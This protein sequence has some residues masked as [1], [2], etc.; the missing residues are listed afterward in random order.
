M[1]CNPLQN[2]RYW[3][4]GLILAFAMP[5]SAQTTVQIGT[6]TSTFG[7]GTSH[8][9]PYGRYYT[10]GKSSFIYT[11]TELTNAGITAGSTINAIG[12]NVPSALNG[13]GTIP[14]FSISML[15]ISG[16]T[17]SNTTFLTGQTQVLASANYAPVV[18]WNTHMLTTPFIYNGGDLVVTTCF[19]DPISNNWSENASV[20][21]STVSNA[22]QY[23][24]S[25]TN[26]AACSQASASSTGSSRPNVQLTFTPA[27][28]CS[29][30]PTGG[31]AVSSLDSACLG[32]SYTLS[33]QGATSASGL[34]YQ[35]E[36]R[37]VGTTT[38][39]P[40][41]SSFSY[42]TT[43]TQSMEYQC[44]VSCG[45]LTA[46]S[47]IKTVS[48]KQYYNCAC[49]SSPQYVYD[50][51]IYN[52][53]IGTLNNTSTCLQTGGPG[54]LMNQY[55][56]Y[57]N[58]PATTLGQGAQYPISVTA[59]ACNGYPYDAWVKVWIDFDHDGAFTSV[60]EEVFSGT[61]PSTQY[62]PAG[63]IA[64][65]SIL[66]PLTANL[67]TTRMRVI[68]WQANS[69]TPVVPCQVGS[70]YNYGE[71]EDYLVDIVTAP[72][73]ATVTAGAAQSSKTSACSGT[74]FTLSAT[75]YTVGQ[76]GL[77]YQWQS[78]PAGLNSFNDIIA[79][80]SNNVVYTIN[81]QSASTDYRLSVLCANT[82]A[83]DYSTPV[84]VTQDS[85]FLCYCSPNTGNPLQTSCGTGDN[86]DSV[87][88]VGTTL[89]YGASTPYGYVQTN[90]SI[91]TQTAT[92]AQGVTYDLYVRQT[93]TG[94]GMDVWFDWDMSGT[95]DATEYFNIPINNSSYD[96]TLN[97]TVPVINTGNIGM[98]IRHY[99]SS[100]G[101]GG[102]C[103]NN[104]GCQ[105][106][107]T[108]DY[109][110]NIAPQPSCLPPYTPVNLI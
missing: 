33:L 76:S 35:W 83:I 92:I 72:A 68:L 87:S 107:E 61:T 97:F 99:Y 9:G 88:I 10:D 6:G 4:V 30:P 17:F 53:T 42:S 39:M 20:E 34:T 101:S 18:G 49:A 56:D 28:A 95:F 63:D 85:F 75:G 48:Q 106:Y 98:R 38:W 27:T 32:Q 44:I 93:N 55:S 64:S 96:L 60:G 84:T 31:S 74:S 29:G 24:Y 69:G 2:L 86:I 94:G 110:V 15:E 8:G 25:D 105:G 22:E 43:M 58:L 57:T 78:S 7:T 81:N 89:G 82:S 65:G 19:E 21:Y 104:T 13:V 77:I 91:P 70:P 103:S 62:T 45:A 109:V 51:E 1:N 80:G 67:G 11:Q 66:I 12:F 16:T 90:P 102:A 37:P 108:E 40:V 26:P 54:S 59:G 41:G 36:E 5:V 50:G 52:V 3:F 79:P 71:T 23:Y 46:T 47:T 73:C 14:G 100:Y